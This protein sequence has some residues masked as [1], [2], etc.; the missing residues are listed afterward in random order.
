MRGGGLA[1]RLVAGF[2]LLTSAGCATASRTSP[3]RTP[4]RVVPSGSALAP[5]TRERDLF[6]MP[7]SRTDELDQ[8]PRPVRG[9][10]SV[11]T[12]SDNVLLYS[13]TIDNRSG[14]SF[15]QAQLVQVRP[16]SSADVVA[17][18]FSDVMMRGR[19]ISVRGTA[20]LVRTLPPEELLAHVREHPGTY[21]VRVQAERREGLLVGF[22]GVA[23]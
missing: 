8:R 19:R 9:T 15:T 22:L 11:A 14:D 6:E 2:A 13:L 20:S 16:D 10:V 21:Q 5:A 23:R 12:R 3:S 18:L 4:I 1:G 7:L 17:T